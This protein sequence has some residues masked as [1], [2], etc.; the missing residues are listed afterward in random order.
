MRCS[1]KYAAFKTVVT[2]HYTGRFNYRAPYRKLIKEQAQT[3]GHFFCPQYRTTKTGQQHISEARTAK[4]MAFCVQRVFSPPKL[5][6]NVSALGENGCRA[7]FLFVFFGG[8]ICFTSLASHLFHHVSFFFWYSLHCCWVLS[9]IPNSFQLFLAQI[10]FGCQVVLFLPDKL[11][12]N[13][14]QACWDVNDFKGKQREQQSTRLHVHFTSYPCEH[15]HEQP[16]TRQENHTFMIMSGPAVLCRSNRL[17]TI[18]TPVYN[19]HHHQHH[20]NNTDHPSTTPRI[21]N[22]NMTRNSLHHHQSQ[23]NKDSLQS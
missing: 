1:S 23:Q 2:F 20:N 8:K 15:Q 3:T 22:L 19:D 14:S 12:K 13:V 21:L 16:S 10:H 7:I 4:S 18:S 11:W 9:G 6:I 17:C 5:V